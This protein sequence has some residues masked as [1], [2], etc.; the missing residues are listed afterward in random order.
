LINPIAKHF[1]YE[2]LGRDISNKT[3]KTEIHSWFLEDD[4]SVLFV[5]Q[6]NQTLL[7]PVG[8]QEVSV[9]FGLASGAISGAMWL[10]S[11]DS[12]STCRSPLG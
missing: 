11:T 2:P 5:T 3:L 8:N 10:V 9:L 12:A 4:E 6:N 1:R 7:M